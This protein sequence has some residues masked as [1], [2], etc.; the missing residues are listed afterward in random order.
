MPRPPLARSCTG[1]TWANSS[2][3][4]AS[5]LGRDADAGVAHPDHDLVPLAR[6]GERD[7]SR[8]VGVLGRVGQQ[9]GEHLLE[10]GR[11]GVGRQGRRRERDAQGLALLVDQRADD[12]DGAV[13]DVADVERLAPQDDLALGDPRDVEQVVDQPGELPGLAVDDVA[14]PL[15]LGVG[16][17]ARP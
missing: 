11:V 5:A 13:D 1:S 6:P 10:P 8:L 9:V 12:L 14:G 16:R 17:A 15:Q 3:T 7:P 2:K 4:V